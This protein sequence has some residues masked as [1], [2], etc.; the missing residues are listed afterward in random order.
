MVF[1]GAL[2]SFGQWGLGFWSV[3][4]GLAGGVVVFDRCGL[5]LWYVG[6]GFFV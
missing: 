2:G 1:V 6:F 3:G 5:N 4:F